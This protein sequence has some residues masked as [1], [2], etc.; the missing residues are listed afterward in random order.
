MAMTTS[1]AGHRQYLEAHEAQEDRDHR[2]QDRVWRGTG[3]RNREDGQGRQRHVVAHEF[4]NDKATDF[5]AI[6]TKIKAKR[7]DLI[8]Y[9]GMD[10]KGGPMVKQMKELGIKAM[11]IFGDGV[12]TAEWPKLAGGAAEGCTARRPARRTRWPSQGLRDAFNAKFTDPIQYAP[13]TYDATNC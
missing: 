12:C 8:M 11:F 7:P 9:G 13:Y 3:R 5:K 1:R 4:T 10:A 2:R 6:L